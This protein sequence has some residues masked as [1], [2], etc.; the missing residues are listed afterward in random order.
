MSLARAT[1]APVVL[2]HNG[3][4]YEITPLT[5]RDFGQVEAQAIL[6]YKKERYKAAKQFAEMHD[7]DEQTTLLRQARIDYDSTELESLPKKK[8]TV[9]IKGDNRM[10][11]GP[12]A[13]WWL[14]ETTDGRIFGIW[15]S[16]RHRRPDLTLDDVDAIFTGHIAAGVDED[17]LE[18]FADTLGDISMPRPTLPPGATLVEA[19]T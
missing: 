10:M 6:A 15:L 17:L 9:K 1:G 12:Y 8:M 11:D 5:L 7:G 4:S 18:S 14:S 3:V 19:A 16:L 2:T 13:A